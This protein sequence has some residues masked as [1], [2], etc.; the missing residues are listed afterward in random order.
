MTVAELV[1]QHESPNYRIK[2]V[3]WS[4]KKTG[5]NMAIPFYNLPSDLKALINDAKAYDA[6]QNAKTILKYKIGKV[7]KTIPLKLF[8]YQ[9]VEKP[10]DELVIFVWLKDDESEKR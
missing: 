10:Y 9:K 8:K 1:K 2:V 5:G 6:K 7:S 3:A 4:F